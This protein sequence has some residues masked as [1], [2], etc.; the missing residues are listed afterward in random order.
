[1]AARQP[2]G[3]KPVEMLQQILTDVVGR[4]PSAPIQA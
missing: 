3:F 4:L 2:A 1:M